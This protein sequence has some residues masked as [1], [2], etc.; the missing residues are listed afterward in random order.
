MFCEL[1]YDCRLMVA[2][3]QERSRGAR[4]NLRFDYELKASRTVAPLVLM[5][6]PVD[7]FYISISGL[8]DKD[9]ST[10]EFEDEVVS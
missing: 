3:G 9:Y 1:W 4:T 2:M 10:E 5:M 6:L 7:I 8:M